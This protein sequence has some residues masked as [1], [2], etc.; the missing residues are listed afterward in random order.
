MNYTFSST[1]ISASEHGAYLFSR[2][3]RSSVAMLAVA[4]LSITS[5]IPVGAG[6]SQWSPHIAFLQP[7]KLEGL[8]T[9]RSAST[10][11]SV[12]VFSPRVVQESQPVESLRQ[13]SG[14]TADQIGRLFGVSR[15]SVQN[16][17][18]GARMSSGNQERLS[19]I[20]SVVKELGAT[21]E[22]RKRKLLDSSSGPSIFHGLVAELKQQ[23]IL[24]PNAYSARGQ[25][26]E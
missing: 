1:S 18:A 20:I 10:A 26:A 13:M 21:P 23:S 4:A 8:G 15:R 12:A 5:S 6:Y 19:R 24:Q 9:G 7:S 2:P 3:H 16:W 22:E 17:V 14:L 25:L 11:S